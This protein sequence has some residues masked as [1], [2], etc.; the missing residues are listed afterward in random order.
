MKRI[1]LASGSPRR[2]ELLRNAGFEFEVRR[3]ELE[4]TLSWGENPVSMVERLAQSKAEAVA[5]ELPSS[6]DA[7]VL[8]ADT[9]VV[10][11]FEVL[12]K[13]GLPNIAV[14]MLRKLSGRAHE[15]ITGVALLS[16]GGQRRVIAHETTRVHFRALTDDEIA[17][18]V[19]TGE[20]LDKAGAYAIQGH[21]G[22]FITRVE[23]C[24]FN[25]MG[26]PLALLDRLLRDW[27][28]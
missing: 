28:N 17:R 20:P 12:G 8:G 9:A 14:E 24:Y 18:Y 6:D 15:V 3:A 16:P 11:D 26:L 27:D 13:P 23:G 1:I 21:A 5:R 7:V 4:E 22:R 19:M 2:E 10:V 25:V